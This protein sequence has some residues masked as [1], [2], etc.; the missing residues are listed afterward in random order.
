MIQSTLRKYIHLGVVGLALNL[1][2]VGSQGQVYQKP[3]KKQI[4]IEQTEAERIFAQFPNTLSGAAKV[5]KYPVTNAQ[6][7]L[8][9][10]R[11]AHDGWYGGGQLPTNHVAY[12]YVVQTQQEIYQILTNV[13]SAL[14]IDAIYSEG[15]FLDD[16]AQDAFAQERR[17]VVERDKKD[18]E[19]YA[20]DRYRTDVI[21]RIVLTKNI[22]T[23]GTE[24]KEALW[25]GQEVVLEENVTLGRY[26]KYV[27]D[28][29]EDGVLQR[30]SE[31]K[32]PLA[33]LVYG[34][35]HLFG[36]TNTCGK[37]YREAMSRSKDDLEKVMYK[38]NKDNI[39]AWNT[40][41]PDE[42][43]SLIEV[44]PEGLAAYDKEVLKYQ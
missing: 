19:T 18:L 32:D 40:A 9:H 21:P 37:A 27:I 3:H 6:K 26:I 39:D 34:G 13:V 22:H 17:S 15:H 10:L 36:G 7:V 44:T 42:K 30:V 12:P 4:P 41:H 20:A 14:N 43:Y 8:V 1:F 38:L 5:E 35:G 2:S 33:V 11:N 28:D 25:K 31:S 23:R 29:R 24:L 16:F